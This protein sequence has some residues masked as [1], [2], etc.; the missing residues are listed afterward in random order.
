MPPKPAAQ[1]HCLVL[2]VATFLKKL[3][4]AGCHLDLGTTT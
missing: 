3:H 1:P 2:Q 4:V